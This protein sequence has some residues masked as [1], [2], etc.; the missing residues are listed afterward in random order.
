MAAVTIAPG[1]TLPPGTYRL[2]AVR[3]AK[4][5]AALGSRAP[6]DGSAHPLATWLIAMGGIGV[7]IAEL[8]A[9][10]GVPLEDG[11]MLGATELQQQLP[12]EIEATYSVGGQVTEILEKTGRKLGRFDVLTIRLDVA[13]EDG[14]R[15][16]RLSCS[17]ILPR[18]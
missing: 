9:A 6:A 15:A 17:M 4:L 16:A 8:F 18:A 3:H 1:A 12:L 13:R 5:L 11:P 7:S 10:A 14:E 2:G